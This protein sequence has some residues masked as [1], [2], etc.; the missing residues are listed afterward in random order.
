[1]NTA[2]LAR[3]SSTRSRRTF[4]S[5]P[6]SQLGQMCFQASPPVTKEVKPKNTVGERA[7]KMK[8]KDVIDRITKSSRK[9]ETKNK[10]ASK[11]SR[12]YTTRTPCMPV[13][14][15][16]LL[17][18]PVN[19]LD[20]NLDAHQMATLAPLGSETTDTPAMAG[21]SSSCCAVMSCERSLALS[22]WRQQKGNLTAKVLVCQRTL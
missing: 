2:G 19:A 7:Q 6:W 17:L 13:L 18:M 11:R 22:I 3:N 5:W 14:M 1:M 9:K 8:E 4:D 12:V 15:L 21:C 16:L 10:K 20:S